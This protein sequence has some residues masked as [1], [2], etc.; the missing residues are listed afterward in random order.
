M[1]TPAEAGDA[2]TSAAGKATV[3]KKDILAEAEA[4]LAAL[5]LKPAD[6]VMAENAPAGTLGQP[7]NIQT[8]AFGLKLIKP[9]TFWRYDIV[10][11][12]EIKGGRKTVF[13]TKKGR[14]DYLITNRNYKCKL[15]FEA[16]VKAYSDFFGEPATLWYDGQSV[17]YA[18]N[19]LF[20]GRERVRVHF[21][22]SL[23]F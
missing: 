18:A 3:G 19:D 9:M 12:A 8:N 23:C 1:S 13:F 11:Y 22:F 2:G 16:V 21:F 17:L 20:K 5:S 15:V 6:A 14:D 7:F 10:I 4:K